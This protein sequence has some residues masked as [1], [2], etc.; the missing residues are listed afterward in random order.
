[1]VEK[2]DSGNSSNSIHTN[3]VRLDLTDEIKNERIVSS[4]VFDKRIDS[5][6]L[7]LNINSTQKIIIS[8]IEE[9]WPKTIETFKKQLKL[10]SVSPHHTNLLCD[11]VDNDAD[12]ILG[13]NDNNNDHDDVDDNPKD[14]GDEEQSDEFELFL[15]SKILSNDFIEYAFDTVRKTIKQENALVRQIGYTGLSAYTNDPLNLGI[16][17]PSS[18]GKTYAVI[19][20]MKLFPK[21]D[22][23]YIGSMTPKV[24]IR[25]KGTIVDK[26]N[27]V[28][29]ADVKRL[30]KEISLLDNGKTDRRKKV[31]LKEQLTSL[32]EGSK[33]LIE[34]SGTIL[35]FLEPPDAELWK[36]IK[37]IL[38]HDLKE[39]EFPYVDTSSG[40]QV[41]KVVVRGWPACIFWQRK[42]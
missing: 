14:S 32:L 8:P 9:N 15:R 10:K 21:Q 20:V 39:I 3:H 6:R 2:Q 22:V 29:D 33:T 35:L 17:A 19:E 7:S 25:L 27:Q 24:L 42:R 30:S 34:L 11:V 40:I 41:K 5:L 38:S 18:E 31:E 4:F 37:P 26:N 23:W 36:M 1:M 13:L 28:I 16:M 12:S